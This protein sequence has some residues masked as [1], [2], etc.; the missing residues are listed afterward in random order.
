MALVA[1]VA[2]SISIAAPARSAPVSTKPHALKLLINGKQLPITPFGGPDRYNAVK[3]STLRIVA[4]WKGALSGGYRVVI[5]TVDHPP[6]R[7]WRTCTT[8]TS[9][10]VSQAVPILKGQEMSW[11]VRIVKKKPHLYTVLGGFMVCLARSAHPS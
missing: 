8:G 7:T 3:A 1:A 11:V 5:S 4:R 9:C 6:I 10:R 2:A